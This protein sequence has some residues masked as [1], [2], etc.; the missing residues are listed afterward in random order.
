MNACRT[1]GCRR[2]PVRSSS[3]AQYPY[4]EE[5]TRAVLS[6]AFGAPQPRT[7]VE[8]ARAGMLPPKSTGGTYR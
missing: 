1:P 5:C 3:G 7:W 8:R 6:A 2:E 4:C